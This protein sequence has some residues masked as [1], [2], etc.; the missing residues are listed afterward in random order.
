MNG[1][2]SLPTRYV[3]NYQD[4]YGAE[5]FCQS[6]FYLF[7]A[8]IMEIKM[9]LKVNYHEFLTFSHTLFLINNETQ[10]MQLL[11]VTI[12]TEWNRDNLISDIHPM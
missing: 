2:W 8:V 5:T 1:T 12:M 6:Y 10:T 9:K 11:R 4:G 3:Y 7:S